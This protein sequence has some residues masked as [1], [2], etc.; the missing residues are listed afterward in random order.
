M[1]YAKP[2]RPVDPLTVTVLRAVDAN[3]RALQKRYFLCGAMAREILL[4]H[5]HGIETDA[6]TADI[7]FGI[8]VESWGQFE[9]I[10][11]TLAA[12]GRFEPDRR[13]AHRLYHK[14]TPESV[15]YPIDIIPFG[16][17]EDPPNAIKWPPGTGEIMNVIGYEEALANAVEIEVA[18]NFV[19]PVISLPG[20]ALLKLF[21]WADRGAVTPK[22]ALDLAALLR[23]YHRADNTDRLYGDEMPLLEAVEFDLNAAS[24]HLLGKDV[25]GIA[26]PQTLERALSLLADGTQFDRL[27]TAMSRGLRSAEDPVATAENLLTRFNAGMRGGTPPSPAA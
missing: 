6:A 21:A 23:T 12:T 9:S 26:K 17:V 14:I 27:V 11:S 18:A 16:G 25:R 20:F 13:I 15:G 22:D 2:D 10:K 5:V 4:Q 19:A 1:L 24:P 7:D 8:A 3:M